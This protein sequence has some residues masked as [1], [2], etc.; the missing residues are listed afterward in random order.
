MWESFAKFMAD[1]KDAMSGFKDFAGG[2]GALTG[3]LGSIW[4]AYNANKLG[5]KQIDLIGQQNQLLT[6]QYNTDKQNKAD[7]NNSFGSVWGR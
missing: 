1:N 7:Q 2:A 5:N 6:D 4:S 3:G